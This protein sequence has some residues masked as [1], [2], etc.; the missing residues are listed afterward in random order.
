[1]PLIFILSVALLTC[2]EFQGGPEGRDLV[3]SC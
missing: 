2:L 3:S 1:M